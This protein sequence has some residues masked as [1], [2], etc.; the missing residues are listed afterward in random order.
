MTVVKTQN[1]DYYID[2]RLVK[3]WDSIRDGKLIAQDDDRVYIVDGRER[4]GKSV[5]TIQ[6]AKYLDPNFDVQNICFSPDEFI[7][8]I[9]TAKKGSCIVFDEAF[10]GLSNRAALSKVN[11]MIIQAL[12]EVGQRN[13]IIFIVLPSFF[14]LDI[15]P[16]MLRSVALFH[17]YKKDNKRGYWR[18]YNF[19]KKAR[20]YQTG[21]K[22]GWSYKIPYVRISGRFFNKY[23]IDEEAYR[24]KKEESLKQ[25]ETMNEAQNEESRYILLYHKMVHI[26]RET[27]D[28]SEDKTSME[29]KR[30]G[31]EVSPT[32]VGEISRKVRK[33]PLSP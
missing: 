17:I 4:S 2:A 15:Y 10:R 31:I 22:K 18:L 20:L 26:Y 21:L 29:L 16:A 11:K 5:F 32:Q 3:V 30:R 19:N 9:R 33:L 1:K 13:L 23:P 25:F 24:M 6:Q 27:L 12:M 14:L 7:K 28:L 8:V